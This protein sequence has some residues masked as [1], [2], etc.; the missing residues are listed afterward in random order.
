MGG[1]PKSFPRRACVRKKC[2]QNIHIGLLGLS[3]ILEGCQQ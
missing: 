3:M 2:A 1:R